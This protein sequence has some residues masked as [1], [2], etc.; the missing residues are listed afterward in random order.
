MFNADQLAIGTKVELEHTSDPTLAVEI[1]MA[2]LDEDRAYYSKL[3][4]MEGR[5]AGTASMSAGKYIAMG[6]VVL[7]AA[8]AAAAALVKI[9]RRNGF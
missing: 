3:E 8:V 6:V 7:V 9:G 4:R 2:H 1:A 5:T